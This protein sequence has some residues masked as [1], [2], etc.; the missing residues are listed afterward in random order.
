MSC[1]KIGEIIMYNSK[2]E[3]ANWIICD[4]IQ[5]D[6]NNNQFNELINIGIGEIE[7]DY[8]IPPNYCNSVMASINDSDSQI[9]NQLKN[10][11]H[12]IEKCDGIHCYRLNYNYVT[13]YNNV[14][15]N[16]LDNQMEYLES[17]NNQDTLSSFD[18]LE[19]VKVIKQPVY[20]LMRYK[21]D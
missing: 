11:S 21:T 8:Y 20:W 2:F 6:N 12:T 18:T 19:K 9:I 4:G 16:V 10:T 7:G 1:N 17:N 5:R 3:P 14:Y 13:N 15:K